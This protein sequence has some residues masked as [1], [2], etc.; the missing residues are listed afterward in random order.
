M[1]EKSSAPIVGGSRSRSTFSSPTISAATSA[2]NAVCAA[3]LTV[4]G[5]P[6]AMSTRARARRRG[7]R[8]RDA[9]DAVERAR[10]RVGVERAHRAREPRAA[11]DRDIDR[12]ARVEAGV[13]ESTTGSSGSLSRATRLQREHELRAR[14]HGIDAH[15]RHRRVAAAP[16]DVDR[17]LIGR[18]HES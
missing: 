13:V 2:A 18:R 15:V 3:A 9:P 6:S 10:A 14:V 4:L 11:G 1:Y 7:D 5:Y 17:E 12:L 16:L 8:G